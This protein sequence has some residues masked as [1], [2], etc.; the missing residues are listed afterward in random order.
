MSYCK[1]KERCQSQKLSS[2]LIYLCAWTVCCLSAGSH[3]CAS[4]SQCSRYQNLLIF[5]NLT[6]TLV[7]FFLLRLFISIFCIIVNVTKFPALQFSLPKAKD[8]FLSW[9]P[10]PAQ[11]TPPTNLLALLCLRISSA[12]QECRITHFH[13]SNKQTSSHSHALTA[14]NK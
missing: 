12:L 2:R 13:R 6:S 3:C 5:R 1:E 14:Q 8:T 10:T 11:C 7:P 4:V 9:G